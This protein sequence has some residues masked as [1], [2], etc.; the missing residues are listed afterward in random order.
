MRLIT[1]I[2]VVLIGFVTTS[3]LADGMTVVTSCTVGSNGG[4]ALSLLRDHPIGGTAVYYVGKDGAEPVRLYA[5]DSDKSRGD[6]VLAAC[7]GTIGRALVLSGEFTS[8]YIQGVAIRYNTRSQRWERIDFA[9]RERPESVYL[10]T[11]EFTLLIPNH[12]RNESGKRFIL[13]RYESG[14]GDVTQIYSDRRPQSEVVKI[15][16]Q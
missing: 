5:G 10:D 3:A 2:P 8:N 13:Y 9:E 16:T 15:R 7:V 12:G 6:D 1:F 14:K 11:R 4:H